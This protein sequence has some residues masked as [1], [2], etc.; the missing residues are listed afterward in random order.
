MLFIIVPV[1][2]GTNI[3]GPLSP[4]MWEHLFVPLPP[5]ALSTVGFGL[6]IVDNLLVPSNPNTALKFH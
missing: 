2:S 3:S 6:L 5:L 4:T 1:V